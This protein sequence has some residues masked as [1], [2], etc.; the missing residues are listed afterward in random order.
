MTSGSKP[1]GGGQVPSSS[2]P[3]PPHEFRYAPDHSPTRYRF[4]ISS[5]LCCL[6][7][8][9]H[10]LPHKP[11]IPFNRREVGRPTFRSRQE[12]SHG[13]FVRGELYPGP[14]LPDVDY[15]IT[16]SITYLR[17]MQHFFSLRS[18]SRRTTARPQLLSSWSVCASFSPSTRPSKLNR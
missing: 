2:G 15:M 9:H 16:E 14:H 17:S 13:V 6:P 8:H 5:R 11:L 1:R 12:R 3:R 7:R 18:G 4:S 10:R